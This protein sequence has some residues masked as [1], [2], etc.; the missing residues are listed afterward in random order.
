MMFVSREKKNSRTIFL[1]EIK[2]I[3]DEIKLYS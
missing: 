1:N 3:S 2:S